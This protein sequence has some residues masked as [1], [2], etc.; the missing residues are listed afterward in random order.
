MLVGGKI[1]SSKTD[2]IGRREAGCL[3]ALRDP[4]RSVEFPLSVSVS[5]V[6]C[7][8]VRMLVARLKRST[9]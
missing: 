8:Q 1:I 6:A 9:I 7:Q 3:M 4:S 2:M 5:V